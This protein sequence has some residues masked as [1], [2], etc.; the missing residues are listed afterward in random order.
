[1][2]V[3]I[4]SDHAG[5]E[6]KGRLKDVLIRLGQELRDEG[7]FIVLTL[8]GRSAAPDL[9]FEMVEV[10]LNTQFLGDRHKRRVNKIRQIEADNFR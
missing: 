3:S 9:A 7:T 10:W 5:F 2:R 8:S 4:G 1:M 6:L